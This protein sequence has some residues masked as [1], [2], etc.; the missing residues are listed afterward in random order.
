MSELSRH[1]SDRALWMIAL[2]QA[3][4]IGVLTYVLATSTSEKPEV[5]V[6]KSSSSIDAP[7]ERSDVSTIMRDNSIAD[8]TAGGNEQAVQKPISSAVPHDVIQRDTE[9]KN[10]LVE[11]TLLYGRILDANGKPLERVSMS[12]SREGEVEP[13]SDYQPQS[14]SR[15]LYPGLPPGRFEIKSVATGFLPYAETIDIEQGATRLEHDVVLQRARILAVRMLTLDD[16]PLRPALMELTKSKRLPNLYSGIS[17]IATRAEP[18]M[19]FPLM[20]TVQPPFGIGRWRYESGP[21]ELDLPKDCYGFFELAKDEPLWI[22][23][24]FRSSL[25]VK[26]RVDAEQTEV[27]LRVDLDQILAKLGTVRLR[28]LDAATSQPLVGAKISL[29]DGH[30]G[31]IPSISD[32]EGRVELL[33]LEPAVLQLHVSTE[34]IRDRSL[35]LKLAPGQVIDLGDLRLAQPRT[36]KGRI[37]NAREKSDVLR[38][39]A[40]CLDAVPPGLS[41]GPVSARVAADGAFEFNLPDGR[42]LVRATR[43]GGAFLEIDSRDFAE[44]PLVFSLAPEAQLRIETQTV[45]P[46]VRLSL[47]DSQNRRVSGVWLRDDTSYQM[48]S[49]PGAHELHLHSL[50]GSITRK[51]IHVPPEGLDLRIPD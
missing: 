44:T 19:D 37:E 28:V 40:M 38:L 42:Y 10:P 24:L 3:L 25:L 14:Q 23:A 30:G 32:A 41:H 15:F 13:W 6:L 5:R 27:T 2:A 21:P 29:R 43:A 16:R 26:T 12:L 36:I 33:H 48:N 49:L 7:S 22:S 9:P 11:G 39:S 17:A 18:T 1:L 47:F 35:Q 20:S 51:L 34:S 4:A 31:G 46:L 45:D 8:G 50:D